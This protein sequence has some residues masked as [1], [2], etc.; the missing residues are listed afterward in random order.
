MGSPLPITS[1]L[2]PFRWRNLVYLAEVAA[3]TRMA[4][5]V[6]R[7]LE[8]RPSQQK[9][10]RLSQNEKRQALTERFFVEILGTMG[11]MGFLHLGQD[12]VDKASAVW[13]KATKIPSFDLLPD[14]EKKVLQEALG[15]LHL[16]I[17]DLDKALKEVYNPQGLPVKNERKG[18]IYRVLYEHKDATGKV[19]PKATLASVHE[20]IV[21]KSVQESIVAQSKGLNRK[22]LQNDIDAVRNAIESSSVLREFAGSNNKWAA[23]AILTGV[24]LSALVGGTVTQWM[25]DRVIAPSAK[26]WLNKNFIAGALKPGA[27]PQQK[28]ATNQNPARPAAPVAAANPFNFPPAMAAEHHQQP[29]APVYLPNPKMQPPATAFGAKALP[30]P[31]T[32]PLS[33]YSSTRLGGGL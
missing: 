23:T 18:L 27:N 32:T 16:Q 1:K 21:A 12:L 28:N 9:D 26:K 4:T 13:G 8:N 31:Y 25:N 3:L 2:L 33:A 24:G 5:G 7:V 6:A 19:V 10:K 30:R 22:V 17:T 15:K 20:N 29:I 11:Y 14:N